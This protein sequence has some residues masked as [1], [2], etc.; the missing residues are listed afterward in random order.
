MSKPQYSIVPLEFTTKTC[1]KCG[2]TRLVSS[3]WPEYG[4]GLNKWMA[5]C[6]DC[7]RTM[8]RVSRSR[9]VDKDRERRRA[10]REKNKES[11][12]RKDR[13]RKRERWHYDKEYKD[14]VQQR[15]REWNAR[16]PENQRAYDKAKLEK[17][18][19]DPERKEKKRKYHNEWREKNR[20]TVTENN[21]R[22]VEKNRDKVNQRNR[23]WHKRNPEYARQKSAQRRAMK[24][25]TMVGEVPTRI[26]ILV[27]QGG[28]CAN[29]KSKE[30]EIAPHIMKGHLVRWHVDHIMP[31]ALGG[32]HTADNVQVLCARCNYDKG[33]K[34]PIDFAHEQGRLL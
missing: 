33:S 10:W 23:E 27:R 24:K 30:E 17:I 14:R 9:N 5:R 21:R 1:T 34:H 3:F 2:L 7:H 19:N 18:R 16:N 6:K 11:V 28:M 12:N 31:L 26:D 22:Y 13:E 15:R 20:E 4:H 32:T 8:N 29:C 25:E